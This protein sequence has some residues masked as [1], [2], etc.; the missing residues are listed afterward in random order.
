[1]ARS[2]VFNF[3][4][5][6]IDPRAAG[7]QLAVNAILTGTVTRRSERLVITAELVDVATGAQLWGERYDRAATDVL[8]VQ[9]DITKAIVD[10]GIRL[11]LTRDERRRLAQSPTDNK[12]AYDLYL[13]ALQYI[14]RE[15]EQDYLKARE[16]L[17]R[18]VAL[19]KNFSLA[20]VALG[21]TY[22]ATAIDG[23]ERPTEAWPKANQSGGLAYQIDP[24]LPDAHAIMGSKAFF[25]DWDWQS[26]DREYRMVMGAA[27]GPVDPEI[28]TTYAQ[29]KLVSGHLDDALAIVRKARE[30]N[31]FSP[32]LITLEAGLL[33]QAQQFE[34]AAALYERETREEPG[35]PRAFFG[36]AEARR[37][38][39]R[40]AEAIDARRR[41][42]AAAGD[43]SLRDVLAN[44][45]G[46][47]GYRQ[48][49]RAT[50]RLQLAEL[51]SR[52]AAGTYVS[53]LDVARAYAQLGDKDQAFRLLSA[54]FDD[55]A[56]GLVFLKVD[57]AWDAIRD[58]ARFLMA[59]RKVGLP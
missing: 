49:E 39:G 37:A 22:A 36:L 23:Y 26:T 17:E 27:T 9:A 16:I 56:P 48:I 40:F 50:A 30:L 6:T 7:R 35:D 32:L 55:R 5:K 3:K 28:V 11:R 43:D 1:M 58:D 29:E 46:A 18:V 54:A 47:E 8:S 20:H 12:E 10:E 52:A 4:G 34:A 13:Q 15:T 41:G 2:T 42:H 19:D 21:R 45:R 33:L 51:R 24:D 53:P 44:A 38:Q 57:R 59:V 14:Y 31:Q 25:F